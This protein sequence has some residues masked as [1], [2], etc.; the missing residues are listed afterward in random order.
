MSESVL[1]DHSLALDDFSELVKLMLTESVSSKRAM[2][3][4]YPGDKH[5][6]RQSISTSNGDREL[7]PVSTTLES[8]PTALSSSPQVSSENQSCAHSPSGLAVLQDD[9]PFSDGSTPQH[10]PASQIVCAGDSSTQSHLSSQQHVQQEFTA[11]TCPPC[12]SAIS[13]T[14]FNSFSDYPAAIWHTASG[15]DSIP[16]AALT[17]FQNP[18]FVPQ[19]PLNQFNPSSSDF[20]NTTISSLYQVSTCNTQIS[21]GDSISVP[22][23]Q[24]F[25]SLDTEPLMQLPIGDNS[26]MDSHTL[27]SQ[28]GPATN[29][30]SMFSP[31]CTE[32]NFIVP[33]SNCSTPIHGSTFY[34]SAHLIADVTPQVLVDSESPDFCSLSTCSSNPEVQDI[35]QQFI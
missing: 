14:D 23:A 18:N 4:A 6:Q 32:S 16:S 27:V 33:G 30:D 24:I 34:R 11:E 35:L 19:A 20:S 12:N 28:T 13:T 17:P 31:S 2:Q 26:D 25:N 5:A 15:I 1:H 9:I 8:S 10:V 22:T 21:P 3:R 7:S 29:V